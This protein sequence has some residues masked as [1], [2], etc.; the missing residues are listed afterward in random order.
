MPSLSPG[1]PGTKEAYGI[2]IIRDDLSITIPPK[3]FKHYGIADGE[4]VLLTTTHIGEGGIGILNREKAYKSVFKK[5]IDL[6]D[7]MNT[8]IENKNRYYA[9]TQISSGKVFLTKELLNVFNLKKGD[10][11]MVVK[12]T[13]VTMSFT[14][15]EI[16]KRKFEQRGLFEA[17]E[18][19]K[20]L[21]VF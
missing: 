21:E 19:M 7:Q 2:S 15:I 16:W 14:P 8:F 13:T 17:V 3:A 20:K 11:L 9:L 1:T 4:I 5:F 6:I 12:S 18:N 10:R